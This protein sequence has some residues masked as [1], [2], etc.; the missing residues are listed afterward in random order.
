MK[1]K[2]GLIFLEETKIKLLAW[3]VL[4][5]GNPGHCF[6]KP[7]LRAF[8]YNQYLI[9]SIKF[10]HIRYTGVNKYFLL[11]RCHETYLA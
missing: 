2:D 1:K 7:N 11:K 5:S 4:L 9:I 8:K 6:F 3:G 10:D